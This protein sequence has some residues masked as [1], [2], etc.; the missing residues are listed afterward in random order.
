MQSAK[1][2]GLFDDES[3]PV[4]QVKAPI[5]SSPVKKQKTLFDD[6]QDEFPAKKAVTKPAA[7]KPMFG[8]DDDQPQPKAASK[9]YG[10]NKKKLFDD[11]D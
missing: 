4:K 7:K 1:K 11:S 10:K 5:T 6:G 9:P 3:E 2:K 8:D